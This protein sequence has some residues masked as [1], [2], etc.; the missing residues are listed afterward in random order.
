MTASL[1][2][3]P[4]NEVETFAT[5][6]LRQRP[7]RNESLQQQLK[8]LQ[9]TPGD[10]YRCFCADASPN[11]KMVYEEPVLPGAFH[12]AALAEEKMYL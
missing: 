1:C 3:L 8:C 5:V 4:E 9:T 11:S 6:T 12:S 10:F 2:N 7:S